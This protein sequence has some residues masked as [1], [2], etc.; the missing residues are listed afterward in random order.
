MAY[1]VAHAIRVEGAVAT[2][3]QEL[4]YECHSCVRC[5]MCPV[6]AFR[7]DD[8]EWPRILRRMFSDP[9]FPHKSSTLELGRGTSEMKDNDVTGRYRRGEAGLC[10]ELGR[11]GTGVT[12]PEIER[13]TTR[14]MAAGV[15]FE[16]DNPLT[17]LICDDAGHIRPDVRSERVLSAILEFTVPTPAL[18]GAISMLEGLARETCTVF[19]VGVITRLEDDGTSPNVTLLDQLGRRIRPNAKVNVGIGRPRANV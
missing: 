11:P 13:F 17:A 15:R 7:S 18:P 5:G 12:L 9:N 6:D 10:V 4:C 2:I 16:P 1:C 3:D 19:S 14:L 8:L